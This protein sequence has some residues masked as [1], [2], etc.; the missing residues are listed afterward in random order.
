MRIDELAVVVSGLEDG[1][2]LYANR[3]SSRSIAGYPMQA[4]SFATSNGGLGVPMSVDSYFN[5]V[6]SRNG[7]ATPSPITTWWRRT[8]E[9]P[10][11]TTSAGGGG[12][13]SDHASFERAGVPVLFIYRGSDPN[14]HSPQDRAE[15]VDPAALAIAGQLTIGV[16][17]RLAAETR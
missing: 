12:G 2:I 6:G 11:V 14:Y 5:P 10:R 1:L 3:E 17:D 15:F 8:R 16:L 13:G 4:A 9:V 7:Y